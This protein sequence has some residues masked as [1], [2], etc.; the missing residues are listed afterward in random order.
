MGNAR[1]RKLPKELRAGNFLFRPLL[2]PDRSAGVE[3]KEIIIGN[4]DSGL[5]SFSLP[6][7][8]MTR[9]ILSSIVS[10]SVETQRC[11]KTT[12]AIG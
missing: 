5:A 10:R 1:I 8:D 7:E 6:A 11:H 9:Y 12:M 4:Q 3:G 2:T